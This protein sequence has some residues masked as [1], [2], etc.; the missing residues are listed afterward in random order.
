M[1]FSA[2]ASF[3]TGAAL[4]A[5]GVVSIK[6]AKK[7]SEIPFASI[8]LIFAA[9]QIMEGFVWLSLTNPDYAFTEAFSSH[10]FIFFAQVIWPVWIP[11]SILKFK[12]N[13]GS[14][15]LSK[16][17]V[18][19][20]ILISCVLGYYLF[21]Q[22][23]HAKILGCHI[24]YSQSIPEKLMMIGGI[25]YAVV[26]IAPTFISPNKRMRVLG[27][28][29]FLSFVI[30]KIFY[31]QYVVSVWCFFAAVLSV[32]VLWIVVGKKREKMK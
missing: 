18:G 7:K 24:S 1:C 17:L 27:T 21:A 3:V 9:Q 12:K 29:I 31:T 4:T 25:L 28:A 32:L 15:I 14:N 20:G 10:A 23:M 2:S 6:K 8:P 16:L 30:A 22:P 11:F 5:V 26:T 13:K 19:I